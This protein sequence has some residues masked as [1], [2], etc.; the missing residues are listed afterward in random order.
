MRSRDTRIVFLYGALLLFWFS[1]E[2]NS[3]LVVSILGA[4]LT[5]LL[6]RLML[7]RWTGGRTLTPSQWIPGMI[8]LGMMVG[9]AAVWLT[10]GMMIFKN[11]WH[12][13]AYPDF[14][15]EQVLG[16]TDRWLAWTAAGGF[17]GAGL[18]LLNPR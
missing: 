11:A 2:S 5:I 3:V 8:I 15:T 14:P 4:G 13:H 17:M 18:A 12:A 1:T 9:F 10:A 7:L 6:A 16:L